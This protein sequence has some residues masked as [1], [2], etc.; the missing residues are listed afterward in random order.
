MSGI[1]DRIIDTGVTFLLIS[2]NLITVVDLVYPGEV[3]NLSLNHQYTARFTCAFDLYF[4]PFDVQKCSIDLRLPWTYDGLVSFSRGAGM[5]SY[6]G[7]A[8]LALYTVKNVKFGEASDW[9]HLSLR[10][11]LHRR[12]G[13]VLLSTFVPSVLLL[14]TS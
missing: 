7:Q 3:N 2:L 14:V 9:G 4:Y 13:L 8:D 6:T 1:Q 12:Q 10:F 11:E 5:A